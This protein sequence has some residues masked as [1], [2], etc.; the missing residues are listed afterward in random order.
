MPRGTEG[1]T[2]TLLEADGDVEP[3]LGSQGRV[4]VVVTIGGAPEPLGTI[5]DHD[6]FFHG[7]KIPR[8][9]RYRTPRRSQPAKVFTS[10]GVGVPTT[11]M[12][13]EKLRGPRIGSSQ[14][15]GQGTEVPRA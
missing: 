2:V 15:S 6:N 11:T 12:A 13:R 1:G 8:S 4:V 3:L 14:L 5:E 10:H 9:L 7:S